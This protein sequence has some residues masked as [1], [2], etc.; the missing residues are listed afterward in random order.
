MLA[1]AIG[2]TISAKFAMP[3]AQHTWEKKINNASRF[4]VLL[5]AM[6]VMGIVVP[7]PAVAAE[8]PIVIVIRFFPA[9]GREDEAQA[10]LAKLATFVPKVNAGVTFQLLRLAKSPAM[11]LM[12]ETFP[13]QAA[14]GDQPKTVLPAF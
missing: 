10:R 13:S 9:E 2:A 4:L 7:A 8:E 11:F 3:I 14:V 1:A 6:G 5:Y 12:Y